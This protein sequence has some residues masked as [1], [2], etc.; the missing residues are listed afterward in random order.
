MVI[1][2]K[3]MFVKSKCRD[4]THKTKRCPK[5][6]LA[7]QSTNDSEIMKLDVQSTD[8]SQTR[9]DVKP[10][11]CYRSTNGKQVPSGDWLSQKI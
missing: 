10:D 8:D 3:Y 6:G 1:K 4:C 5:Q 11:D 2:F 9:T 7:I